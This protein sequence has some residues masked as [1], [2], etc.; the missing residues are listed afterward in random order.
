MIRY[1]R[2]AFS[3]VEVTLALG[4]IAFALIAILGLTPVGMR[5]AAEAIDATRLSAVTRD[6]QDRVKASINYSMFG[7]NSDNAS[8]YFYDREATFVGTTVVGTAFYRVDAVIHGS[9]GSN[10]APPNIDETVLRPV[11]VTTRWPINKQTG[12]ALGTNSGSFTFYVR[13]P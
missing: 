9:W 11:T 13:R 1:R 4:L 12:N 5:S 3:L 2:E 6:T 10:S 8:T 7:S